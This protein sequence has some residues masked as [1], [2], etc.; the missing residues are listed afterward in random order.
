MVGCGLIVEYRGVSLLHQICTKQGS[1]KHKEN[2][3]TIAVSG[4]LKFDIRDRLSLG[5]L[6]STTGAL[7]TVLNY[8]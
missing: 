3:E 4:F 5:E 6:R 7:Q 2:P 1:A 8:S